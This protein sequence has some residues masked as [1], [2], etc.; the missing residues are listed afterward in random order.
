MELY[1]GGTIYTLIN[2]GETV[3]A[4][5][6][7]KGKIVKVGK[8]EELQPLAH[9]FVDLKGTMMI[10][11][12]VD[13]HIHLI[14]VGEMLSRVQL[15][16]AK[17][18]EDIISKLN[19]AAQNVREGE[20]LIAEGWNEFQLRNQEMISLMELDA[21][22]TN[23]V[24]LHRTCRHVAMVNSTVIR[25]A[26]I[27][28]ITRVD[29][30]KVGIDEN[31][32]V[33]GLLYD[34]ATK[35]ANQLLPT[36]GIAYIQHLQRSIENAVQHLH[37]FGVV[38]VHSEDCAYY[39]DYHNVVKAYENTIG[40]SKHFRAHLLR[41]HK[42]FEQ[43]VTERI[44][45]IDG[46]IEY[47]PMKIFAD[48]S[49]GGSTAALTVPYQNEGDN[50][51]LLIHSIDQFESFVKTARK[52]NEAIAVHMIGDA[53]AD[54]VVSMIEKYPT[55]VGKRDRLIHACLMNEDLVERIQDLSVIIDIQPA[56]VP[57]D[58]P[59][60]E[61]KL[62]VDR[63]RYAYAWKML[64]K[65]PCAMGTDAPIENVNPFANIVAAVKRNDYGTIKVDE[66]LTVFEAVKMYTYGSAY[67]I[68]KENERGLIKEN[69]AADFTVLSKDIFT[70]PIEDIAHMQAVMTI[71]NGQIVY[72]NN[73]K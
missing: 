63:L 4:V 3:E 23:P 13:S 45:S 41:H 1:F 27:T 40:H 35:L 25:M 72:K 31:G 15:G 16:D 53:A 20:W 29:G 2:E 62:G 22:T 73:E 14:G 26:N 58:F 54:L 48:G 68:G 50:K 44:Q 46:F 61:E 59:W 57:S 5:L 42:V 39:G 11:G 36:E 21:I 70:C 65:L 18:K 24:I 47:G 33:N 71:V 17:S 8:Y 10:P 43:M 52:Y 60:I 34:E 28:P 66:A 51:G 12:L 19:R 9:S 32:Q 55:P 37:R 7:N 30:G 67:A 64:S 38:G 49:F 6:V 56:F 69:Y